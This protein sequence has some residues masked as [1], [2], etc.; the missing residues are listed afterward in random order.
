MNQ[1]RRF[2]YKGV[3]VNSLGIPIF[4]RDRKSRGKKENRKRTFYNVTFRS[5]FKEND[6][7][8]LIVMYDIPHSQKKERDWFRR[9]LVKFGYIMIQK[10]V[11]VGPSPLPKDFLSYLKKIEIGDNF[12]TFKLARSYIKKF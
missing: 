1:K 3:K 5:P 8:N 4:S 11:W 9:H 12:K 7:K 6:S 10:S 2:F